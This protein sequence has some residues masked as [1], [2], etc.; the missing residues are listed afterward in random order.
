[1]LA[2]ALWSWIG[3]HI[4]GGTGGAQDQLLNWWFGLIIR[5]GCYVAWQLSALA[6]RKL[7]TLTGMPAKGTH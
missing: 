1:M 6:V 7:V 3:N 2:V 4:G 5:T